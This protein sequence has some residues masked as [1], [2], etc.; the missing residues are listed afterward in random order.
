MNKF[1]LSKYETKGTTNTQPIQSENISNSDQP[2]DFDKY[3]VKEPPTKLQETG[4]HIARTASRVGET[5]LGFPGDIV[6]LI[7]A[8]GENLPSLPKGLQPTPNF[9]Q[10]AGK[11]ALESLPTS[12]DLKE[13][14]SKITQGFT[15]P[16]G[17]AEELGDEITS[18][19]TMLLSPAKAVKSFP[20]FLKNIGVAVSKAIGVKSAGKV[21]ESLGA[22]EQGKQAAELGTLFLT[23][24]VSQKTADK[25]IGEQYQ[26]AR[27]QIPPGT[28]VNT[29]NLANNLTAVETQL[30]RGI[31][32][33]TKD[34][35]RRS[36]SELKGKASGG[37][38]EMDELVE[39]FHNINERMNSKKLFDELNTTERKLL[40][41]RYDLV[42]DE[43][44]KEISQYAQYNPEFYKTWK[45]ANQG[46]TTIAESK[47]L[48]N[49]LQSKLGKIPHHLAGSIA[50]DLFLKTPVST[51]G[52]AT[53]YSAVKAGEIMTRIA[54]SPTL[55]KHYLEVIKEAS[56]ENLPGVIKNL[57]ILDKAMKDRHN[58][59]RDQNKKEL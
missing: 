47:K 31:S 27:S 7:N 22:D 20:S 2:F 9:I 51:I 12:Q 30:A 55:R 14:S 28:M 56:K 32:T 8:L 38:M 45:G 19:G 58:T 53:G 24:L 43:V 16:Q 41:N 44:R 49:F 37:A 29:S 36:L 33:P 15:D 59:H 6:G 46:F 54:K 3:K 50:L 18:L 21:A 34:E 57:D 13:F 26:K 23:G 40:K 35:V 5:V 52:V 1:D 17:A 11:S 4:R 39:S 10:R 25:F 48:R 42:K